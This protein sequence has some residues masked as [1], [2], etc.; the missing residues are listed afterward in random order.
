MTRLFLDTNIVI[1][2]SL[3]DSGD[4]CCRISVINW[5]N[6]LR[7]KVNRGRHARD[8][9]QGNKKDISAQASATI[10]RNKPLDRLKHRQLQESKSLKQVYARSRNKREFSVR[11]FEW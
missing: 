8:V 4:V 3:Q 7:R 6:N 10:K 11:K 5:V 2:Y 1:V 9:K